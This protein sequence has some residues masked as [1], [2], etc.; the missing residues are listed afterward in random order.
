MPGSSSAK[1]SHIGLGKKGPKGDRGEVGMKGEKGADKQKEIEEYGE[2]M[3]QLE[4]IVSDQADV[5]KQLTS[6]FFNIKIIFDDHC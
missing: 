2:R 1:H 6:K 3:N 5:I 4:S